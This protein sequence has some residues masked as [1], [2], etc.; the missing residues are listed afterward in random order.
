MSLLKPSKED[1][2]DA[3]LEVVKDIQLTRIIFPG[4]VYD[5]RDPKMLG[6]LRVL[7]GTQGSNYS[8]IV[9][10]NFDERKAWTKEDPI[11]FLPLLPFFVSQVPKD[12]EYVHTLYYDSFYKDGNRF[13]IQGPYSDPRASA[14]K[15]EE[16]NNA[17]Q[18]LSTGDLFKPT[19]DIKNK[20]GSYINGKSSGVYPE[21][22]DN[23]LL[24]RGS[25]DI[26]IKPEEV[27]LRAGK[28]N[29]INVK[30]EPIGNQ[31][32]SFLQLSNFKEIE[33]L[34]EEE[35]KITRR[36]VV[37][38]VKKMVIWNV[39]NLENAVLPRQYNGSVGIYNVIPSEKVNTKNFK[40][41]SIRTLS[42]GVDYQGPLEEFRFDSKSEDEIVILIN[43]VI[44]SLFTGNI[45]IPG[46]VIRNPENFKQ[47]NAFPF[48]ITPSKITY[49]DGSSTTGIITNTNKKNFK[50]I[51][52][53]IKVNED[54]NY[55]GFMIVSANN[56]GQATIGPL[57]EI[58]TE[59]NESKSFIS[60][61]ITYA[62]MGAQKL[63]L[64]SHNT[65]G[66]KGAI[67]LTD[68]LYGIPQKKFIDEEGIES[69][70]YSSVRG[71]E[72]LVLLRK[73]MSYV[74]GHV[75]AVST[76]PP[77]TIAEGNGQSTEEIDTLL[78]S[79]ENTILNQNIRIN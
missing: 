9:G 65:S 15:G 14:G 29:L 10:E 53:Q 58:V 6:R 21:P 44:K 11:L 31:L 61:P 74:K 70:T 12:N 32:R 36:E 71:E 43:Q 60:E 16:Q 50:N 68:T 55:R 1:I 49:I 63:Y 46:Y 52:N 38:V 78:A 45:D 4:I 66:P 64:L 28:T 59:N 37:K 17:Q 40:L 8:K 42:I 20:D 30:F 25:S 33:F 62:A 75:H 67:D 26:V 13:Y 56:S 5:N 54:P 51:F 47:E 23:S 27:L 22:G 7:P 73:I 76:K 34:N 24:G 35:T 72:L 18:G 3:F 77:I 19:K 2:K 41:E 39:D 57:S 79:A 48:V 69:K